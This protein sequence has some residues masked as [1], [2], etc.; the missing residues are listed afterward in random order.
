MGMLLSYFR[1]IGF[2]QNVN[3]TS[4][5][6]NVKRKSYLNRQT[7]TM[8]SAIVVVLKSRDSPQWCNVTGI[9]P[10]YQCLCFHIIQVP[11]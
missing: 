7:F 6:I 2:K 4:I 11:R 9:V 1:G 10:V 8:V 5:N 3:L